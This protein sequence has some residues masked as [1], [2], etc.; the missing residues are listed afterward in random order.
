MMNRTCEPKPPNAGG[1]LAKAWTPEIWDSLGRSSSMM[2]CTDRSRSDQS[3][4]RT[5]IWPPF[6]RPP[7]PP[8]PPPTVLV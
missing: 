1:L 3:V 2:S 4:N 5:K 6:T 7:P 8:K